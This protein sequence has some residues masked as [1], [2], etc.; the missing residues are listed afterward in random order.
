L[1]YEDRT[2]DIKFRMQKIK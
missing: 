1:D 2:I